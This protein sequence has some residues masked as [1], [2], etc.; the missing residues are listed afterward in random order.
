MQTE[1]TTAQNE[2]KMILDFI[3]N[4]QDKNE[5][6]P[7]SIDEYNSK[8]KKEFFYFLD[9]SNLSKETIQLFKD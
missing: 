7:I 5:Y 1:I 2:N 6:H 4:W 3:K 9:N 8:F